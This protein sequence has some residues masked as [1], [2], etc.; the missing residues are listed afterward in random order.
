MPIHDWTRV[1]AGVFHD[2]HTVWIGA[3]RN[4]MNSGLLPPGFYAMAEQHGGKYI[5]DIL[6]FERT[7]HAESSP[8]VISGGVAVPD[9]PPKVRHQVSLSPAARTRRKTLAIR[10]S[11]DHR[12]VAMLEMISPANKDRQDHLEKLLTKLDDALTHGIHVLVIDLFPPSRRDPQGIHSVLWNWMGDEAERPPVGE[13][14]TVA[15]YVAD[16]PVKAY[17]EYLAVG[18]VLP[19]MPLFLD[20]EVY[21]KT[22]LE[23]TYLATW[24]GTP[25]FYREILERPRGTRRKRGRSGGGERHPNV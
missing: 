14:L 23:A 10:Q 13:P 2:F 1:D 12:L 6:T 21:V 4:A 15:S 11:P 8:R 24:Q 16:S 7:E 3:L 18:S 25:A 20:P 22:P 9:A 19:E 17:V 5:A